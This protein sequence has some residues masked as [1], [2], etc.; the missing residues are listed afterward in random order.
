MHLRKFLSCTVC[1]PNKNENSKRGN[2]FHNKHKSWKFR[3][4]KAK[5]FIAGKWNGSTSGS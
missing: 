4:K 3:T 2:Q 1:P 5:Q